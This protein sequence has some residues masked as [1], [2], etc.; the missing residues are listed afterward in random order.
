MGFAAAGARILSSADV[1]I[2]HQGTSTL[3]MPQ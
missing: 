1:A 3:Y 2:D